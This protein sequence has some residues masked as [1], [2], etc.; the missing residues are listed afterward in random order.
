MTRPAAPAVE[1][2]DAENRYEISVE[3]RR[4]GFVA[5][6]DRERQRVFYHTEIDDAF[7]GKGLAG[8][9]VRE[10]LTDARAAGLRLVAVCPYVAKF[11]KRHEEFGDAVDPVTP[12][13]L[14]WLDV[15]PS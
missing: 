8:V 11:V 7:A 14:Q 13:I 12:A 10:A 9:L 4:A 6:R 15:K 2:D 5:Y 3:G 1:R